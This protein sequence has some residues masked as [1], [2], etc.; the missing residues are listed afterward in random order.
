VAVVRVSP[1]AL[2]FDWEFIKGSTFDLVVPVLDAVDLPVDITGWTTK[3]QAR[4]SE[5]DPLRY[6]WSTGAGNADVSED[7]AVLHVDGLITRAWEWSNAL[8]SVEVYEADGTPHVIAYGAIH[9]LSNPT[10]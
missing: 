3:T 10:Q 6:E 2:K 4:R 7:G 9:A 8:F 1:A 5:D